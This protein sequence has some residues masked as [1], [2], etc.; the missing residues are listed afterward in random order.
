MP[1]K[2]PKELR[3]QAERENAENPPAKGHSRTAEGL[4]AQMGL[5]GLAPEA[6]MADAR[7]AFADGNLTAAQS[8]ASTA[9]A[10]WQTADGRG[11][12]RLL[13]IAAVAIG[14]L[15]LLVVAVVTLRTRRARR[16]ELWP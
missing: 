12:Q 5:L 16:H 3:E 14:V 13:S 7:S 4:F 2:T 8:H 10:I 6:E 15:V 9:Q 11:Q 1:P